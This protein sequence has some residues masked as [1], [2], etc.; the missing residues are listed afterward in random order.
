MIK[1]NRKEI[2]V[3]HFP[4]G[5]QRLLNI[6]PEEYISET[7]DRNDVTG[8]KFVFAWIY[9]SDSEFV[10]LNFLLNHFRDYYSCYH[11]KP[12]YL[13]NAFY[14]PNS[15]MDRTHSAEEVF[16]LKWFCKMI[17]DLKLDNVRILDPHSNVAP[18]LIDNVEVFDAKTLIN[19]VIGNIGEDN[20]VLYYPDFGAYK[21]YSELLPNNQFCYGKKV[22]DWDSGKILGLEIENEMNIDLNGKTVLMV[23]DIIAY[24]GSMHFGA[25]KLKELGVDKIYAYATHT[26]N[27][28]LD[29][30][31]GTLIKSLGNGTVERLFTTNSLFTG[32]HEKIEVVE[33]L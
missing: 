7:Y 10:T 27:S 17:N 18:A 16:T 20:L 8:R 19:R 9:E 3:A 22:R 4:D 12:V 23:D 31:K 29:K 1:V 14:F 30:E 6:D 28:V 33:V 25:M 21:K 13:L 15:R 32:K 5:T 11:L 26:E 2:K 24:G